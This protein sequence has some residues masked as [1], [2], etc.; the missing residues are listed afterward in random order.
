MWKRIE[1][2]GYGD[3]EGGRIVFAIRRRERECREGPWARGC[4]K[5]TGGVGW[6]GE[7]SGEEREEWNG[8]K[9][10]VGWRVEWSGE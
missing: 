3:G 2:K 8:E 4:V 9:G 6:G 5:G 10:G 1:E 7:W